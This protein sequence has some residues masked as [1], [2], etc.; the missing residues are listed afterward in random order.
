MVRFIDSTLSAKML[1]VPRRFRRAMLFSTTLTVL[2]ASSAH[3]ATE[4]WNDDGGIWLLDGADMAA[5]SPQTVGA[6]IS[7][8]GGYIPSAVTT[9]TWLGDGGSGGNGTWST[10]TDWSPNTWQA[11]NIAIFGGT[12]GTVTVGTQ[13]AGGLTFNVGGYTLTGGTLTL[14]TGAVITTSGGTTTFDGTLKLAGTNTTALT[15]TGS[16]TLALTTGNTGT[17]G[18]AANPTAWT[19][20]GGTYSAGTGV[21]DSILSIGAGN[22]LGATPTNATTQVILDAGTLQITGTGLN[23]AM[24]STRSIQVNAVGGAI[25]DSTGN[26]F[27]DAIADNAGSASSLYLSNTSGTTTFSGVIS[28]S[29]GL[30]WNGAGTLALGGAN[31]YAGGTTLNAGTVSFATNGNL[32]ANS[33]VVN[34]AG[35]TLAPTA[36][37]SGS[38]ANVFAHNI[39]TGT[40]GGTIDVASG[41]V[42]ALNYYNNNS[43][44]DITGSGSLTKVAPGQLNLRGANSGYSG[45]WSFNGG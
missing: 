13:T 16:G 22:N 4:W 10:P 2:A 24:G 14:N 33:G 11:G 27:Q 31:T 32:G 9:Q 5:G 39:A 35:G 45:T 30:T 7:S 43:T 21:F 20:T 1:R 38:A 28:G 37:F 19:V 44:G 41:V 6:L 15:K 34:L 3:A 23:P 12:A 29:G 18:M 42:F 26:P 40:T 8:M 25:V 36:S 17:L